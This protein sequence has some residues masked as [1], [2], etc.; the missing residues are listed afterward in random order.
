MQDSHH[1]RWRPEAP[2]DP[3]AAR[4]SAKSSRPFFFT[5]DPKKTTNS[6][7]ISGKIRN[8]VQFTSSARRER[9]RASERQNEEA[10]WLAQAGKL[11]RKD[12]KKKR[13]HLFDSCTDEL[14]EARAPCRNI[15]LREE[16]QRLFL[17]GRE[18][19]EREFYR[20]IFRRRYCSSN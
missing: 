14:L 3:A 17:Q 10:C 7:R 19:E 15:S 6:G 4:V 12:E 13:V 1:T 11:A 2:P 5:V 8:S 16:Q 20:Y 18:R 9:E